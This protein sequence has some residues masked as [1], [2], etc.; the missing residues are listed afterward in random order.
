LGSDLFLGSSGWLALLF[1]WSLEPLQAVSV[2]S[3]IPS[4]GVPFSKVDIATK[5]QITEVADYRPLET[6]EGHPKCACFTPF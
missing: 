1:I 3:L 5:A 6:Q 2:L 4:T